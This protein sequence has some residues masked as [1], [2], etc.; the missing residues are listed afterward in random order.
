LELAAA[1]QVVHQT[2]RDHVEEVPVGRH[3]MRSR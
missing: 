3:R 2:S 1:D